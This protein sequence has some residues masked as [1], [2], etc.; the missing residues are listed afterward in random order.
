MTI[1][2]GGASHRSENSLEATMKLADAALYH[3]KRSGR[4]RFFIAEATDTMPA[5]ILRARG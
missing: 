3:A 5:L 1:S 4:D 2:V